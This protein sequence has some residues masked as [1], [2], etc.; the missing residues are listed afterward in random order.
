MGQGEIGY[1]R[2]IVIPKDFP[3]GKVKVKLFVSA[4]TFEREYYDDVSTSFEVR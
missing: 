1:K 3:H 4:H 2:R